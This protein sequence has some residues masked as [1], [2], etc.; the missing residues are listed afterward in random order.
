MAFA[1]VLIGCGSSSSSNNPP[2]ATTTT[3]T[4]SLSTGSGVV[5]PSGVPSWAC[6]GSQV[7][8]LFGNANEKALGYP[9]LAAISDG[10]IVPPLVS[11]PRFSLVLST[12]RSAST[13]TSVRVSF[14]DTDGWW[15]EEIP[16]FTNVANWSGNTL[17][18][19][20][21][22]STITYRVI[23]NLDGNGN[24]TGNIYYRIRQSTETQCETITCNG[25]AAQCALYPPPDP[26]VPC[27]NYMATTN[28]SVVYLGYYNS[29]PYTQWA[30]GN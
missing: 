23:S 1:L 5:C 21:S 3:S 15:A 22:S 25:T 8:L 11:D 16:S 26:T 19:I 2:T 9:D 27:Q 14:E 30:T 28:S 13:T 17:D 4:G 12:S 6:D 20:N 10:V 29:V 24:L 18:T 7:P